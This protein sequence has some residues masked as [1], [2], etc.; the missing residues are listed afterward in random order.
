M[1]NGKYHIDQSAAD[2][3]LQ[4]LSKQYYKTNDLQELC[5]I[6]YAYHQL[7]FRTD[8]WVTKVSK[9]NKKVEDK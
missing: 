8:S 4:L 3:I 5:K 1:N 7:G 2:Y 9:N 6:E